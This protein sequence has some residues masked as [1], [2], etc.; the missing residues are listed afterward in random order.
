MSIFKMQKNIFKKI[1]SVFL[2]TFILGSFILPFTASAAVGVDEQGLSISA[3]NNTITQTTPASLTASLYNRQ[4]GEIDM[5]QM[6]TFTSIPLGVFTPKSGTCPPTKKD[7]G[8]TYSCSVTF[9]SNTPGT[10]KIIASIPNIAGFA[11]TSSI[12]N[13]TNITVLLPILT[14]TVTSSTITEGG[15]TTI[16]P[17]AQAKDVSITIGN[18]Q[19]GATISATSCTTGSS[20]ACDPITFTGTKA[21]S[22]SMGLDATGYT[23]G[24]AKVTV[25]SGVV[26]TE[27]D[28][29]PL[30]PLPGVGVK[31][32][33]PDSTGKIICVKTTSVGC[34]ADGTGCTPG[35][36]FP[37]YLNAMIKIFIGICAILAMIMIIMGGV[38]YMT[39]EL[40][41]GKEAGKEQI[42]HAILGLLLALG[43]YAILN[44]INPD[45]LDLSL[46]NMKSATI[47]ISPLDTSDGSSTS[48]CLST[49]NPPNPESAIGTN[50]YPSPEIIKYYIPERNKL[51]TISSGTK[52]LA[53]AQTIMEGFSVG[54]KSF[55]TN[56]PGNIG[57]TDDSI[58][59]WTCGVTPGIH[60]Y[61][62]LANGI[63]AQGQLIEAAS[64]GQGSYQIGGTYT[65]ALGNE[66]YSGYLYQYLRIY[67]GGARSSNAYVNGIIGYFKQ[68]GITITA[69]TTIAEIVAITTPIA[70]M[71]TTTTTQT[72][73][74]TT[75]NASISISFT[76]PNIITNI[77]GYDHTKKYWFTLNYENFTTA[78]H[79]SYVTK[80]PENF[81]ITT[82]PNYQYLNN[83]KVNWIGYADGKELGRG[84]ITIKL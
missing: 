10:Y 70:G 40:V 19:D 23:D 39:S 24:L 74:I 37:T 67:A 29:Y 84:S 3:S 68:N 41:S 12:S 71:T 16:T 2:L 38:Q 61:D 4:T 56:N 78:N 60:C 81:P 65:C 9:Q 14:A 33:T 48:L 25:K 6:V 53:T 13:T 62:T 83:K 57:N 5:S 75:S 8:D 26:K 72:S 11:S 42:M 27:T 17:K 46:G 73:Q 82:L 45:L 30:A 36:G 54:T 51:T 34:A 49:T 79:P 35:S 28:Y 15:T 50:L 55:R 58:S 20:F 32:T 66:K 77:T 43:A 59:T 76:N 31:C 64:K 80:T 1:I 63:E 7:N 52:L 69:K 44:T 21:G 22:Y 47:T 18:P